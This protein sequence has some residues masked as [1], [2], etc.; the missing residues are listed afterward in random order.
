[1]LVARTVE[2][3]QAMAAA[4]CN[5]RYLPEV[6]LRDSL[7]YGA[8]HIEAV[9]WL[10]AAD[11]ALVV[12]S[13]STAGLPDLI[14]R[15]REPL[16]AGRGDGKPPLPLVW[17][18]KG[19]LPGQAVSGAVRLPHEL[20]FERLAGV[21]AAPLLGPSFALEVARGQPAALTVATNNDEL[22]AVALTAFHFGAVRIYRSQD[23]IGVELGGALKNVV[24]IATGICDGLSLGMNARA[25]LVTRGLAEITRLGVAMG[26]RSETFMGLTGLGDLV[27]TATGDL[28]RNR[29]VGLELASGRA[30]PE[31]LQSL[32]HVAEGVASVR[33][34]LAL[35]A[36]HR[37]ELPICAAVASVIEGEV[38]A[39]QAV[40][41]L[42]SREPKSEQGRP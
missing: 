37:V 12:I 11:S 29:K 2:H 39:A 15:L 18:C 20:I 31:I 24:A 25:A 17:L 16:L 40:T 13:S 26:A 10:L 3:A 38:S 33:S 35:G 41:R 28:S 36:L 21:P 9:D 5:T 7:C 19:L 34:A 23:V 1:M 14:E 30:L 6:P 42:L 32:G 22:A 27:L 8:N 4:R